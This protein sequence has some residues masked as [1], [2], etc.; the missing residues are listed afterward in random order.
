MIESF[1]ILENSLTSLKI[2]INTNLDNFF[3]SY[4]E[5]LWREKGKTIYYCIL[6]KINS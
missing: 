6:Q 2:E 3:Q 5:K 1:D 4:F